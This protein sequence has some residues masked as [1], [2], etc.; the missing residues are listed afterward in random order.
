MLCLNAFF[1][2][3]LCVMGMRWKETFFSRTKHTLQHCLEEI[4]LISH[5]LR[6]IHTRKMCL[7]NKLLHKLKTDTL[8][9]A[10]HL[11]ER[12]IL[13]IKYRRQNSNYKSFLILFKYFRGAFGI[14]LAGLCILWCSVSAS[15]LFVTAYTMDHQQILIAYPCA[16]LY[17]VF[18]L[19]TIF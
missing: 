1:T 6:T 17:G 12:I 14:I 9:A 19:I 15:K 10:I 16:L 7:K 13:N 18:A 2:Y 5:H 11:L 8:I 4:L 3:G